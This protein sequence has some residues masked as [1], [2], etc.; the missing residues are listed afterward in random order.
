VNERWR[1]IVTSVISYG[2][3]FLMLVMAL[4]FTAH[5]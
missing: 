2:L 1:A 4:Y 3:L 5:S